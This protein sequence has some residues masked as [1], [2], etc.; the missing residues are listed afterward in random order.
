MGHSSSRLLPDGTRSARHL[1]TATFSDSILG[2][3]FNCTQRIGYC[4]EAT[5]PLLCELE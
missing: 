1:A 5:A 4:A 3:R 2:E